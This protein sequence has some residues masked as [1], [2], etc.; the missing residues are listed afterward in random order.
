V[1][2]PRH[3]GWSVVG[4]HQ[5]AKAAAAKRGR[6]GEMAKRAGATF[7]QLCLSCK[8][9]S[10]LQTLAD[11]TDSIDPFASGGY[12]GGAD[13]PGEF[14]GKCLSPFRVQLVVRGSR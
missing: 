13:H 4:E 9:A 5:G 3:E 14:C 10:H 7:P 2:V 12:N 1:P 8:A 11:I 6:R